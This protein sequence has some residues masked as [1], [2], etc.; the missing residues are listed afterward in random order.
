MISKKLICIL[1][2]LLL[3]GAVFAVATTSIATRGK[4]PKEEEEEE[5]DE[6]DV[7]P[8][9]YKKEALKILEDIETDD[10]QLEKRIEKAIGYIYRSLNINSHNQKSWKK[11]SLWEDK[12]H[13]D[14]QHGHTVFSEEKKAVKHLMHGLDLIE[15]KIDE[16]M[17]SCKSLSNETINKIIAMNNM[18]LK[19]KIVIEILVRV[20]KELAK[21]AI[22]QAE[23][24]TVL[25][26]KKQ[27]KV[28][29]ETKRAKQ[30]IMKGKQEENIQRPDKAIDDYRSAWHHA[31]LAMKHAAK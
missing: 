7:S 10:K 5:E 3:I 26:S 1:L 6:C 4:D 21:I 24:A 28:D 30:D 16:M 12:Y 11:F 14:S 15:C 9:F 31:Q 17:K 27:D 29:R 13:L 19:I 8:Q 25:D 22:E 2:I 20:D 23:N 18:V